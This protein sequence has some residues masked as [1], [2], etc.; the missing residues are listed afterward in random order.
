MSNTLSQYKKPGK[1]F[2]YIK[3]IKFEKENIQKP[4]AIENTSGKL[5]FSTDEKLEEWRQYYQNLLKKT[6]IHKLYH[7]HQ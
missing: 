3:K 6:T 5:V 4:Q 7:H 2:K 1:I